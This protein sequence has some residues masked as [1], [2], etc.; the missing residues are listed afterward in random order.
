MTEADKSG[1]DDREAKLRAK[2]AAV[3]D[4]FGPV[5]EQWIKRL[6]MQQKDLFVDMITSKAHLLSSIPNHVRF[7]MRNGIVVAT[8]ECGQ[9]FDVVIPDG[10]TCSGCGTRVEASGSATK[11]FLVLHGPDAGRPDEL[12]VE[13][14]ATGVKTSELDGPIEITKMTVTGEGSVGIDLDD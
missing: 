3:L 14:G 4:A 5:D 13:G 10:A 7:E 8:C 6:T 9:S 11:P 1:M 12:Q 2:T